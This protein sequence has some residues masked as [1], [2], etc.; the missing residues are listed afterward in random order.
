MTYNPPTAQVT[1]EKDVTHG[2]IQ[3]NTKSKKDKNMEPSGKKTEIIINPSKSDIQELKSFADF[4][5]TE[6]GD[7]WH[8]DPEQDRKL[9]GP[10][11]INVLVK[12]VLLHQNQ[13]QIL[14]NYV[15]VNPI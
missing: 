3:P 8:P 1:Q 15:Q 9:G 14:K 13:K 2:N 10:V 11:P 7:F 5:L 4:V 6:R 12:I